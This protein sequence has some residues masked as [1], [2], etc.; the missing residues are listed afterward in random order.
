MPTTNNNSRR[1]NALAANRETEPNESPLAAD[2]DYLMRAHAPGSSLVARDHEAASEL[3]RLL[4]N[5]DVQNEVNQDLIA[6]NQSSRDLL[7]GAVSVGSMPLDRVPAVSNPFKRHLEEIRPGPLANSFRPLPGT[8]A[9]TGAIGLAGASLASA[10]ATSKKQRIQYKKEVFIDL[11]LLSVGG[12]APFIT[13][14]SAKNSY[15]ARSLITNLVNRDS[16]CGGI[17]CPKIKK[18]ALIAAFVKSN[19]FIGKGLDIK[20]PLPNAWIIT[21][22][23]NVLIEGKQPYAKYDDLARFIKHVLENGESDGHGNIFD[24]HRF[25]VNIHT[26]SLVGAEFGVLLDAVIASENYREEARGAIDL[27]ASP[28]P[29]F[30]VFDL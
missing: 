14:V 6:A 24:H 5:E 27:T 29:A 10:T 9:N 7:T 3:Q 28:E 30:E 19:I 20:G 23:S 17:D 21:E 13:G 15:L 11:N 22:Q 25:T 4:N 8:P 12:E 18:H 2:A 1:Q 26:H 16:K